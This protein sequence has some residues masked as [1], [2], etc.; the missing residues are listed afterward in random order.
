VA[1]VAIL[2]AGYFVA[3][4]L[5][6]IFAIP[7]GNATAVWPASGI[8]LAAVLHVGSG[9]WPGVWAGAFLATLTTGVSLETAAAVGVGNTLEALLCAWLLLRFAGGE[10]AFR[11]AEDSFW[12]AAAAAVAAAVS[13]TVGVAS[14]LAGGYV[15][16]SGLALNWGTWWLGDVAGIVIV[17]PLLL[18]GT[19]HRTAPWNRVATAETGIVLLLMGVV[20]ACVFGGWVSEPV[21]RGLLFVP[22]VLLIWIAL[23]LEFR[24]VALAIGLLAATA[25][26]GTSRGVGA[27][28][29]EGLNESLFGL[30]VFLITC[31]VTGLA[32]AA[33]VAG[34]HTAEN[35]LRASHQELEATV[36]ERTRE[37]TTANQAL[38]REV[39]DR[40]RAEET[41]RESEERFRTLFENAGDGLFLLDAR[42]RVVDANQCACAVLGYERDELIGLDFA[43]IDPSWARNELPRFREARDGGSPPILETVHR[44]S[45]GTTFPVELRVA[46]VVLR[47]TSHVLVAGRNISE[48]KR[49]HET[50]RLRLATALESVADGIMITDHSGTIQYVNPAF[51]RISGFCRQEVVG[52]NPSMLQ[53]GRHDTTFYHHLW[54]TL[55][56]GDV[57]RGSFVDKK[58][59]NTEYD[60]EVTI[61]SIRETGGATVGY[62]AVNRD[63]TEHRRAERA[64]LASQQELRV[65]RSI[66]QRF[67]PQ[68][69][70]SLDG[71]DIAGASFPAEDTGGDYFDYFPMSHGR[72][73]FVIADVSGH[74]L[75]PALMMSQTRA[76]LR[77]LVK[78]SEDVGELVTQL[79]GFLVDDCSEERFVTL[80]LAQIDRQQRAL[81]YASAGHQCYLLDAKGDVKPL[82]ATSIPLGIRHL[83]V[84][85]APVRKLEP[86][87]LILCLTDGIEEAPAPDGEFFG[88]ERALDLVR[89]VRRQPAIQIVGTL[90]S[91]VH[92]FAGGRHPPDDVTAVIVKVDE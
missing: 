24:V 36:H 40:T 34:R 13:A 89:S 72:V 82:E 55:T 92:E 57:W 41:Q 14:L 81:A 48:R 46:T 63:V 54:Q 43:E 88:L 85:S 35:A 22:L 70:P 27:F 16:R 30:Q 37:L 65:A 69:A 26:W 8:A 58:K 39:A 25:L 91:T 20:A 50:E 1:S 59:D 67:F 79:N 33:T 75:G 17:A 71:F 44:R 80:F 73:G 4:R 42:G 21:A 52:R 78:N 61:A 60:A 10:P 28:G 53:S 32:L 77:A 23:R 3:A 2:A 11:R 38:E 84:P 83:E 74:G 12:C 87:D 62:V 5:G 15:S 29:S 47:G 7:P 86:G 18:I 68:S 9:A 56:A 6:L 31:A 64:L 66:Q 45:D 76:Y 51:E 19:R 90:W 49:I